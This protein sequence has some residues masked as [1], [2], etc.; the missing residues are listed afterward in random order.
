MATADP[1]Y[2]TGGYLPTGAAIVRN[3]SGRPELVGHV[4]TTGDGEVDES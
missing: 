4:H 3:E 2:A 1:P